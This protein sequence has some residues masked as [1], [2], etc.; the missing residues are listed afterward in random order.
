MYYFDV[1]EYY[2]GYHSLVD[3][4]VDKPN[5]LRSTWTYYFIHVNVMLFA[6]FLIGHLTYC[7]C[8]MFKSEITSGSTSTCLTLLN[9]NL[10]LSSVIF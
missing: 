9:L 1:E 3:G 4:V 7:S 8:G 6:A 2:E 5:P 10:L